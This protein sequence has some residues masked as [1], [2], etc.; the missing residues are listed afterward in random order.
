MTKKYDRREAF[1]LTPELIGELVMLKTSFSHTK[2]AEIAY[3]KLVSSYRKGPVQ[4]ACIEGN[5]EPFELDRD[6][7]STV[8][9]HY[10]P[11]SQVVALGADTVNDLAEIA[12]NA[13]NRQGAI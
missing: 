8:I 6:G 5:F 9:T 1:T 3:G 10:V 7:G 11:A 13:K 2:E 12:A 4:F